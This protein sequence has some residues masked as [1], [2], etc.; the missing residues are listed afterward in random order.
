MFYICVHSGLNNKLIPLLSLLRIAKKENRKILCYW[1]NDAYL[2]KS[3]F[4]FN[5]LFE[6]IKEIKFISKNEFYK[7]YYNKNNIIYN[8]NGS[9]RNKKIIYKKN[10]KYAVFY[11]I[12][13][14]ISYENDN[15]IK[16]ISPYPRE[17][18]KKT[19]VIDDARKYLKELIPKKDILNK[20]NI[21]FSNNKILGI[22]LRTTD[23]S[24]K[25]IPKNN[26]ID[27]ITNFLKNNPLYKIYISCDNF[28]I[29]QKIIKKFPKKIYYFKNPFG[30]KYH[31]KFDRSSFGTKNAVVEI[32]SLAK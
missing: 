17:K 15:I 1:D 22:H 9:D 18:I 5:D 7:Q 21:D 10:T 4:K 3:L 29:E 11:K 23:G 25:D 24:F 28:E 19:N 12:V 13:H 31:D 32:F 20:I 14:F 30:N 26:I 6:N 8:K 27:Y 2:S 16:Y